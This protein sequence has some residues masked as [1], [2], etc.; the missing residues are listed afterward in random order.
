LH[1]TDQ[2]SAAVHDRC[3]KGSGEGQAPNLEIMEN[4]GNLILLAAF[5]PRL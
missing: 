3:N 1:R 2:L 5:L 4:L